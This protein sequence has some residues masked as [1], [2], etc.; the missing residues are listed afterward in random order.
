MKP[1]RRNYAIG[2]AAL[3]LGGAIW[4]LSGDNTIVLIAKV[5]AAAG[6]ILAG[7]SG[8]QWWYYER[9]ARSSS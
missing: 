3:I 1:Y 2:L 4:F 9:Q 6:L 5:L 7:W 8:R